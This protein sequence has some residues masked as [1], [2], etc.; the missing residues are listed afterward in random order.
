MKIFAALVISFIGLVSIVAV[1]FWFMFLHEVKKDRLLIASALIGTVGSVFAIPHIFKGL[2]ISG[3][4]KYFISFSIGIL[5]TF[6]PIIAISIIVLKVR[7]SKKRNSMLPKY[8]NT[9]D[10]MKFY[11]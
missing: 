6:V 5:I 2:I 7:S 8:R 9:N 4:P 11:E 1:A 10:I 3:I